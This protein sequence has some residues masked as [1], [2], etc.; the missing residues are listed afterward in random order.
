MIIQEHLKSL[1]K[2]V[3]QDT[4]EQLYEEIK[5]ADTEGTGTRRMKDM[6]RNAT[7]ELLQ[8]LLH[9]ICYLETK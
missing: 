6:A 3:A 7:Y 1:L 4:F 9:R 5:E 2:D 8:P